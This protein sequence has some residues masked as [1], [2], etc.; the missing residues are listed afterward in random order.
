MNKIQIIAGPC[1]VESE[2]QILNIAKSIKDA[3]ADALRGGAFKPRTSPYDF[4]GLGKIGLQY[5]VNAK[6]LTGLPIVSEVLSIS[7]LDFFDQVDILQVGA[8]NMQNFELLK[9]L[10]KTKKTIL[11]KRGFGNTVQEWLM[12]AEYIKCEGNHNIIL[13]ERGI[14]SFDT[15]TRFLLDISSIPIAQQQGY[16][17]YADPS[18]ASGMA[19]IVPNLAY[20]ATAAGADGL[21]IECH[22]EPIKSISDSEQAID[23]VTLKKTIHNVRN[24][25][26]NIN[27]K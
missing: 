17:V 24:I 4:Q 1:S 6:K 11:L 10:G 22:T 5:L 23:I 7:Q 25:Q 13:C 3:G 2:Q 20:A 15:K 19:K 9:N 21:M 16:K 27:I 8:R 26:K 12:S 18:H 14:R